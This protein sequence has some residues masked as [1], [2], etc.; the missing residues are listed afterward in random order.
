MRLA[1]VVHPRAARPR[2]T[3]DGQ[4]LHVWVT[5]PPVRGAANEALVRAVAEWAG[6]PPSQIRIVRGGSSRRKL[7]ELPDAGQT[8]LSAT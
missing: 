3:W 4:T 1:V 2:S 5:Q 6:L 7:V 8:Y